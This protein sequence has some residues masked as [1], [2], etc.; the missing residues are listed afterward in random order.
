MKFVKNHLNFIF[1]MM[2]ILMGLEFYLIF[3]R[4]TDSYEKSLQEG[5]AI[6]IVAQKP[7]AL[8]EFQSIAPVI[9]VRE[10]VDKE[11]VAK[12]IASDMEQSSREQI[13]AALPYFYNLKLGRY[14]NTSE[15]TELEEK[16]TDYPLIRRVET[17]GSNYS[18]NYRLFSFIKL[19]LKVFLGLMALVSLL[20]IIKQMEIWKYEHKERMKIMEIFGAPLM[21]RSGVLFRVALIDAV[22]SAVLTTGFFLFVKHYWVLQSGIDV[23]IQNQELLFELM[24]AVV[25]VA[26][27]L[28]IVIVAVYLVVFGSRD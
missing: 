15:L 20:M 27:S 28:V 19:T 12:E 16:L 10:E 13:L 26:A 14:L 23:L 22:L 1:P 17:F 21:L 2:A 9:A 7:I 6:F 24:D 8:K 4:M 25:L 18:S 5:Y 3:D 11:R